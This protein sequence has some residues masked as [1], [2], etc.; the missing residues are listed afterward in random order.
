MKVYSFILVATLFR[1]RTFVLAQKSCVTQLVDQ[2]VCAY[3]L[4]RMYASMEDELKLESELED[5]QLKLKEDLEHLAEL[6]DTPKE[7]ADNGKRSHR[8]KSF[9]LY[10]FHFK[11][12]DF[13]TSSSPFKLFLCRAV[14]ETSNMIAFQ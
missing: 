13:F 9:S 11:C 3:N 10:A 4:F 6:E 8:S 7:E 1:L 5:V 12:D 14:F 2:Y